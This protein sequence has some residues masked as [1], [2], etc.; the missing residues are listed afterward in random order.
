MQTAAVPKKTKKQSKIS[1]R[2]TQL[3]HV[4]S[5]S[6][7]S[8]VPGK[9]NQTGFVFHLVAAEMESG[10]QRFVCLLV[11]KR[12]NYKSQIMFSVLSI[13]SLWLLIIAAPYLHTK[14]KW[15]SHHNSMSVV[16]CTDKMKRVWNIW[17]VFTPHGALKFGTNTMI[18][19]PCGDIRFYWRAW[20]CLII[21]YQRFAKVCLN[22]GRSREPISVSKWSLRGAELIG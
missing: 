6:P 10:F 16:F 17:S 1:A 9:R 7:Q 11:P 21:E 3:F 14:K 5:P 15:T 20:K 19:I 22:T 12:V 8:S 18:Q 13:C 2:I 4:F